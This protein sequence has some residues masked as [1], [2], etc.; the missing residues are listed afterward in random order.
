MSYCAKRVGKV[1][2][3]V[4][5]NERTRLVWCHDRENVRQRLQI[6]ALM[7]GD[8]RIYL[9]RGDKKVFAMFTTRCLPISS[10]SVRWPSRL[11]GIHPCFDEVYY[12]SVGDRQNT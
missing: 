6:I 4:K 1:D 7:N 11:P 10:Y 5:D 2:V 9:P 12:G 8:E 3:T